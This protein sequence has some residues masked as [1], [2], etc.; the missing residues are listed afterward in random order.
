MSLIRSTTKDRSHSII[1]CWK[2][3]LRQRE[4]CVIHAFGLGDVTLS[5]SIQSNTIESSLPYN[6]SASKLSYWLVLHWYLISIP[7]YGKPG[8]RPLCYT[9]KN[10]SFNSTISNHMDWLYWYPHSHHPPQTFKNPVLTMAENVNLTSWNNRKKVRPTIQSVQPVAVSK[11]FFWHFFFTSDHRI[12]M[13]DF[14][15][16]IENMDI[17]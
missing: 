11:I 13:K 14:Q 9:E 5:D 17:S 16:G 15:F 12:E 2:K 7:T 6:P 4:R 3:T 10:S 1:F 8:S